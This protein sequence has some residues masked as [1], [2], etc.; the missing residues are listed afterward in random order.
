MA[1]SQCAALIVNS[2]SPLDLTI[3]SAKQLRGGGPRQTLLKILGVSTFLLALHAAIPAFI[4]QFPTHSEGIARS[5]FCEIYAPS[6]FG[7][8]TLDPNLNSS[9]R[10]DFLRLQVYWADA[11]FSTVDFQVQI[12]FSLPWARGMRIRGLRVWV[13]SRPSSVIPNTC[14]AMA[15]MTFRPWAECQ[16]STNG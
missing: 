8:A 16:V 13:S 4:G 6:L 7:Y 12:L 15:E 5:D 1:E 11:A 9:Y 3:T 10:F 2:N 14:S